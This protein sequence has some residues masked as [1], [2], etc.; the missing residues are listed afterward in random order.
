M[1]FNISVLLFLFQSLFFYHVA[2]ITAPGYTTSLN[3]HADELKTKETLPKHIVYTSVVEYD[4]D[5][6]EFSDEE[7]AGL[8][9]QAWDEMSVLHKQYVDGCD[10]RNGQRYA[11]NAKPGMMSIIGLGKQLYI[12]SS[13]KQHSPKV[14]LQ[15][16]DST[17]TRA[18]QFCRDRWLVEIQAQKQDVTDDLVHRTGS[19]CGEIMATSLILKNLGKMP[20]DT[21]L[22]TVVV[23]YGAGKSNKGK[24]KPAKIWDPCSGDPK[25]D[26][27]KPIGCMQVADWQRWRKIPEDVVPKQVDDKKPVNYLKDVNLKDV[28]DIKVDFELDP[29]EE[30]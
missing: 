4:F 5:V 20:M 30:L 19:S 6:S 22:A 13:I 10:P 23:A 29:I 14:M 16:S 26:N 24:E 17:L 8:G 12:S 27:H 11:I 2:A 9:R 28:W 21:G 7:L 25:A 15:N 3:V 18:L 1:Q